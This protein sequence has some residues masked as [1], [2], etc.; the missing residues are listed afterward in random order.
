MTAFKVW[1]QDGSRRLEQVCA[2]VRGSCASERT[3]AHQRSSGF[4]AKSDRLPITLAVCSTSIC[5]MNQSILVI[6]A[7]VMLGVTGWCGG[8]EE[9]SSFCSPGRGG[10]DRLLGGWKTFPEISLP[11]FSFPPLSCHSWE[12]TRGPEHGSPARLYCR[13]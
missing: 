3:S 6:C 7:R 11:I 2:D 1:G 13:S 8:L 10:R 12:V 4:L 5:F 9:G